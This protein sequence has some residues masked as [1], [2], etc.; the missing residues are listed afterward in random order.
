MIL[1][2]RSILLLGGLKGCS[3]CKLVANLTTV[4]NYNS[5]FFKP[6]NDHWGYET[7][8]G[9]IKD[10][11]VL[12]GNVNVEAISKAYNDYLAAEIDESNRW[13]RFGQ[14][15]IPNIFRR[16]GSNDTAAVTENDYSAVGIDFAPL[17][18]SEANNDA[19]NPLKNLE[20]GF[21]FGPIEA[22]KEK[23]LQT[24]KKFLNK[25]KLS[26]L[27]QMIAKSGAKVEGMSVGD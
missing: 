5:H 12:S 16:W 1:K 27:L 9:S 3:A 24:V 7:I 18:D 10:W 6:D 8:D 4:V 23:A 19:F 26:T 15:G 22:M 11:K 17:E 21:R 2:A 13:L 25:R 20:N 14:S